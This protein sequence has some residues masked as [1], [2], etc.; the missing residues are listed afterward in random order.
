MRF[1]LQCL[2][3][4]A[5]AGVLGGC[6]ASASAGPEDRDTMEDGAEVEEQ[7]KDRHN[8]EIDHSE[9]SDERRALEND[10][11][12]FVTRSD[13]LDSAMAGGGPS[14][15]ASVAEAKAE[16]QQ[17][18]ELELNEYWSE[19]DG[20]VEVESW[21]RLR[22][23][24]TYLN[25]GC[26]LNKMGVPDGLSPDQEEEYRQAIGELTVPLIDQALQVFSEV[27]VAGASPWA[28]IADLLVYELDAGENDLDQR[29]NAT[30]M[31][32]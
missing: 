19:S 18:L 25:F 6:A 27:D 14:Q 22:I 5:L 28:E 3:F 24:Q 4:T 9:W 31:Y 16:H 10:F 13:D 15:L 30:A 32:W 20:D 7:A 2:V 12:D 23:G 29:C 26:E 21:A 17:R 11:D 1:Y 8:R